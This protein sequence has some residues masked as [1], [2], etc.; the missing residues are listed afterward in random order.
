MTLKDIFV[1]LSLNRGDFIHVTFIEEE[2]E[3]VKIQQIKDEEMAGGR[4][5]VYIKKTKVS[6]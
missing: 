2:A 3:N 6:C 1:V 4:P 5:N